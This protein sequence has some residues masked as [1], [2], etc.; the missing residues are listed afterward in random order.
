MGQTIALQLRIV[1]VVHIVNAATL[2]TTRQQGQRGVHATDK[3]SGSGP[4]IFMLLLSSFKC[5]AAKARSTKVDRLRLKLSMENF[6]ALARQ[7]AAVMDAACWS[8]WRTASNGLGRLFVKKAPV[9]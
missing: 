9:A 3:A 4:R 6:S 5:M 1:V 7:S 8:N 2:I